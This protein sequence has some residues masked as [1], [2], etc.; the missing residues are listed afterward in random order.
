MTTTERKPRRAGVL[1]GAKEVATFLGLD[2]ES[3]L[4]M[5][6]AGRIPSRYYREVV[7]GAKS[8]RLVTTKFHVLQSLALIFSDDPQSLTTFYNNNEGGHDADE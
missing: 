1:W 4:S 6:H 8:E 2:Y 5:M 3:A 7:P